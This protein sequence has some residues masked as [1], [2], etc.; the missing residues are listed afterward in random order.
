MQQ[1]EITS[2]D[3]LIWWQNRF[4]NLACIAAPYARILIAR[5][6][7]PESCFTL[8]VAYFITRLR[9][10]EDFIDHTQQLDWLSPESREELID[11]LVVLGMDRLVEHLSKSAFDMISDKE[12]EILQP[13]ANKLKSRLNVIPHNAIWPVTESLNSRLDNYFDSHRATLID[14]MESV[15]SKTTDDLPKK[16]RLSAAASN[17]VEHLS[18]MY[19]LKFLK[20]VENAD[21]ELSL[22]KEQL[23]TPDIRVDPLTKRRFLDFRIDVD[24]HLKS[25]DM[26]IPEIAEEWLYHVFELFE[27]YPNYFGK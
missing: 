4:P 7:R 15:T 1:A 19:L 27:K 20:F 22:L 13:I 10:L 2:G 14:D 21:A 11:D 8:R 12:I 6:L 3:F 9:N 24:R 26:Q 23:L 16:L 17:V 5:S 25:F 18:L